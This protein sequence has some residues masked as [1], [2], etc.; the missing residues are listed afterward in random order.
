V[1]IEENLLTG[2]I[3]SFLGTDE[4]FKKKNS[5]RQEKRTVGPS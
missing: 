4:S 2:K 1:K 5:E 3:F